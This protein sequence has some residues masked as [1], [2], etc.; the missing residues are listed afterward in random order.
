AA[1]PS[2]IESDMNTAILGITW[3]RCADE[4]KRQCNNDDI[5]SFAK[6]IAHAGGFFERINCCAVEIARCQLEGSSTRTVVSVCHNRSC[7]VIRSFRARG[8]QISRG[9]EAI[10]SNPMSVDPS[11]L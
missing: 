2:L 11:M 9:C 6:K 8:A 4:Q 10:N 5:F 7:S 1:I 3:P